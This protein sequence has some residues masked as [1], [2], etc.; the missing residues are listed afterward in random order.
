[1]DV[2]FGQ[3]CHWAFGYIFEYLIWSWGWDICVILSQWP[4]M[5]FYFFSTQPHVYNWGH[6]FW[7]LSRVYLDAIVCSSWRVLENFFWRNILVSNISWLS[8]SASLTSTTD[9]KK[10][11]KREMMR[12]QQGAM[13]DGEE[14]KRCA[15]ICTAFEGTWRHLESLFFSTSFF[16]FE[17]GFTR[18][19]AVSLHL[20][21]KSMW[22]ASRTAG[23]FSMAPADICSWFVQQNPGAGRGAVVEMGW[24]RVVGKRKRRRRR[25]EGGFRV[26]VFF[27]GGDIWGVFKG[28]GGRGVME[29]LIRLVHCIVE[30]TID[31]TIPSILTCNSC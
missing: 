6:I 18:R 13:H 17:I 1:M 8:T 14:T 28:S 30:L 24:E 27:H 21:M 4:E 12:N 10:E 11:K 5:T 22:L 20:W 23:S 9:K 7:V 29:S 3:F 2:M 16:F 31:L 26:C 19:R 25:S 15:H